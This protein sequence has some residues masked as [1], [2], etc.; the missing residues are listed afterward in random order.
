MLKTV[1]VLALYDLNGKTERIRAYTKNST[2]H[3]AV[4]LNTVSGSLGV[5]KR[6]V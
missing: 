3:C 6:E 1:S 4:D 2:V 5:S